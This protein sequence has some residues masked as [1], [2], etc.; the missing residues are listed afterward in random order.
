[1]VGPSPL[2]VRAKRVHACVPV[3]DTFLVKAYLG[4]ED[5][6]LSSQA[7]GRAGLE[8]APLN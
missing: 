1:M 3:A 8:G 6:L 7:Q 4:P 2:M 5:T